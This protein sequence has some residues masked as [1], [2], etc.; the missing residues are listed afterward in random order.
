MTN[1]GSEFKCEKLLENDFK[2]DNISL[3]LPVEW[4]VEW[5]KC[6]EYEKSI[7]PGAEI[8]EHKTCNK[9]FHTSPTFAQLKIRTRDKIP[10]FTK[11]NGINRHI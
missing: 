4:I 7:I 5:N 6:Q 2:R 11:E 9:E 8:T 1:W 10:K 3:R